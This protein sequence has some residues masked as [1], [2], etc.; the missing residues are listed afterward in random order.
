MNQS[1]AGQTTSICSHER[2]IISPILLWNVGN[3]KN[4]VLEPDAPPKLVNVMIRLSIF[5]ATSKWH[6]ANSSASSCVKSVF[7]HLGHALLSRP[8]DRYKTNILATVM[9]GERDSEFEDV[10]TVFSSS[11]KAMPALALLSSSVKVCTSTN[12]LQP[13]CC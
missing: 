10:A 3:R 5:S 4:P 11:P 2:D 13:L 6:G 12:L 1:T 7:L 9:I 8:R